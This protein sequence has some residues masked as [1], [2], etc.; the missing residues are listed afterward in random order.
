ML[1]LKNHIVNDERRVL[2]S[3]DDASQLRAAFA[4]IKAKTKQ[5]RTQE[6]MIIVE[7]TGAGAVYGWLRGAVAGKI[8]I[9]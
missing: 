6:R 8:R 3:G 4:V 7:G 5:Y 1:V 2:I 9:H